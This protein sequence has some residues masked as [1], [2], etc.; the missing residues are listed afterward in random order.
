[1]T[2]ITTTIGD[3]GGFQLQL[4]LAASPRS[5]TMLVSV[6]GGDARQ[7]EVKSAQ[8]IH[9]GSSLSEWCAS[10]KHSVTNVLACL[11]Y[12]SGAGSADASDC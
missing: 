4:N 8:L 7:G 5:V 10:F 1:M 9:V 3:D 11:G 12:S 2:T 6:D